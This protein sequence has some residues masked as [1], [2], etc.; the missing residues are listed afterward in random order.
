MEKL[1]AQAQL[2]FENLHE[3]F[4]EQSLATEQLLQYKQEIISSFAFSDFVAKVACRYPKAFSASVQ[5]ISDAFKLNETNLH[6]REISQYENE[7]SQL[8]EKLNNLAAS[9]ITPQAME[10]QASAIVRQFRHSH[11]L[12][13]AFYDIHKL[14]S[15]ETSLLAVSSL[16]DTIICAAYEFLYTSLSKRYGE[17]E[18]KQALLIMAMGKLGGKELNFSSDIDLIFTYPSQGE[19]QGK[20]AIEHQVFFTRLAQKLINMLSQITQDAFAY[21]VDMRLRPMGES[22][23]LVLPFSALETYYQEQ[24]R[25]WERFAMQK[26]RIVNQTPFNQSLYDIIRPFVYRKYIDFTTIESIREMKELIE[27]EVRRRQIQYNIKL[28]KGGIREVEFFVQSLQLIHAGRNK[29][30]QLT[31]IL[32]SM[33][34]L[35]KASLNGDIDIQQLKVD[36]LYLRQI[37]HYLQMF[38]DEQTQTL[39]FA[40]PKMTD[41][42]AQTGQ[43][44]LAAL[45]GEEDYSQLNEKIAATM[46]RINKVFQSVVSDAN[47]SNTTQEAELQFDEAEQ[48]RRQQI[49][50]ALDDIWQLS[51]SKSEAIDAL[52]KNLSENT[53]ENFID[54]ILKFKKKT[55]RAGVSARA[56]KSINKLMPL[57]LSEMVL[58]DAKFDDEVFADQT[59]GVFDILQTICGRVTYIDLLLEHPE[60]R[61]RLLH[62]CKKSPWVSQQIAQYPILLDELLHPVY[63]DKNEISLEEYKTQCA[64]SLRQLMLRVD[65]QDEEQVMDRLR[66]FKHTTQLRIAAADISG[67]LAINQV[68]DRLTILAEVIM[69]EVI[70]LAWQQIQALYG[71]PGL[72]EKE[73]STT[74]NSKQL[75][76]VAYGKFGGIELSY[77]SDLDVV[78]LHNA[79]LSLN[80]DST[81]S[82]KQLS[83]QEFYIKL[84][85]RICHICTTKTYNGILYDIDLR[86]RPSGNSGLLITHI[87]SFFDYQQTKAWTW[88]HQ[89]LVRSRVVV[90]TPELEKRF[91]DVRRSIL[92]M[93]RKLDELKAQIIEMREKMRKHLET[94]R[95]DRIDIKQTKG[96]IVDIEFLVQYLILG[97]A[98]QFQDLSVWSDNLRLLAALEA[99]NV[100]QD[101]QKTK[102]IRAYLRLRHATH[103]VQL[104]NK[105]MARAGDNISVKL[106]EGIKDV[107]KIYDDILA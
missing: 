23:P 64:D 69:Q 67:T 95:P 46:A 1:S 80:T 77:G 35:E 8:S 88:E 32:K 85:Q 14:Q 43:A 18:N 47:Q 54:N 39:P 50:D 68:S 15:I 31:S 48:S 42:D 97:H 93:P 103:R 4:I 10:I 105:K 101:S 30:C 57:L 38:N 33:Q 26:M 91:N 100:I 19:T 90:A 41:E 51:L 6:G 44:R 37:E 96:G 78:F 49:I 20:K 25:Q 107:Q 79:D 83:N 71:L 81:G 27:K 29:S 62:L 70:D 2:I 55:E 94:K 22:G 24:G 82:R 89:A 92:S 66:E 28:G 52:E 60:V 86:L 76:L 45:F 87:D 5:R 59:Q 63:L 56:L 36:Y 12:E 53:T 16:A 61:H 34:A 98:H 106:A 99:K 74:E 73:T 3:K 21:R 72:S 13:I 7:Y 104:A 11:M 17:P 40:N 58:I 102:L 65:T 9:D 84:V 75:A